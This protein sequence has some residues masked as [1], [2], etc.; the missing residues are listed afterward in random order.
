MT[1]FD[2]Y[3]LMTRYCRR[4]RRWPAVKVFIRIELAQGVLRTG[5]YRGVQAVDEV[6]IGQNAHE[7]LDI[8]NVAAH[9]IENN[10]SGILHCRDSSYAVFDIARVLHQGVAVLARRVSIVNFAP[11]TVSAASESPCDWANEVCVFWPDRQ[12]LPFALFAQFTALQPDG[13]MPSAPKARPP[14]R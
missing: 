6:C 1:L 9:A 12:L 10:S 13:T 11:E 8:R 2:S 5:F 14:A 4:N 3:G 7:K